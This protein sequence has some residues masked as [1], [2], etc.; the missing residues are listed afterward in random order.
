MNFETKN[1]GNVRVKRGIYSA[2]GRMALKLIAN[3]GTVAAVLT[4][5]IPECS[6]LL[7][8]GE[9]FVKAW[10]ENE[11]IAADALA[12]GLFVDTG[13][14]APTGHTEAQI[15]RFTKEEE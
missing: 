13:R 11:Q 14:R 9:F 1:Y 4:V 2:G 5:N 3:D 12:S 6:D 10:S 15:W 8:P 7:K